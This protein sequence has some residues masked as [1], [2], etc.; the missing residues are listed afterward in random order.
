MRYDSNQSKERQN[1][2]DTIIEEEIKMKAKKSLAMALSVAAACMMLAGSVQAEETTVDKI[3][4]Q[5]YI[6]MATDAA[7]SI[8]ARMVK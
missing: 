1:F 8:S 7:M 4:E 2:I 3:I 5:G 6:T